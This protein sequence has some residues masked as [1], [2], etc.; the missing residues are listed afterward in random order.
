MGVVPAMYDDACKSNY[1]VYIHPQT[2]TNCWGLFCFA[3]F[4]H[5]ENCR[6]DHMHALHLLVRAYLPRLPYL[7]LVAGDQRSY[8]RNTMF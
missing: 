5:L 4:R 2:L 6:P 8:L 7:R 1:R 3:L